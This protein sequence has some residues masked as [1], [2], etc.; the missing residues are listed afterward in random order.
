MT[1]MFRMTEAEFA[2]KQKLGKVK[3]TKFDGGYPVGEHK[4]SHQSRAKVV[5]TESAEQIAVIQWCDQHP[6]AKHIFA[7]P[8]GS[9]K[10]PAAAA[11]FKRE[12][13]RPG[14]PDLFLP[15]ARGEF[16][17]MFI[18]MKRTKGGITSENQS[19][20]MDALDAQGYFVY[21]AKGAEKAIGMIEW[22]LKL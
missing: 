11:K 10:S 14:I 5:P 12:G 22:Y 8:N 2:A 19:E 21:L 3:V 18:E 7:I 4:N 17:G 13:L 16:H 20:V 1:K 6:V 9:H 15:V